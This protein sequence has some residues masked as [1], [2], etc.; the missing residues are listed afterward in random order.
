MRPLRASVADI[1]RHVNPGIPDRIRRAARDERS[2]GRDESGA[3]LI[4][5]LVFLVTVERDRRR[6]CTDWVSNDLMNSTSF[7]CHQGLNSAATNVVRH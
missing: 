2:G 1:C 7:I 3:V 4:L 6:G 5:A